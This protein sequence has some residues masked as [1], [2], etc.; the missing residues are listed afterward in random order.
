[1]PNLLR[2]PDPCTPFRRTMVLPVDQSKDVYVDA[3][4]GDVIK[5]IPLATNCNNNTGNTTWYGNKSFNAGYYGWPNNAWLLESHCP[6]EATMR[7]LRGDPLLIYNYGDADGS[8]TDAN[9]V[10]GYN[11]RAG[12]TTYWASIKLTIIIKIFIQD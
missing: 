1:M 9:G 10:N 11:Q 5:Q 2:Q 4:T 3:I 12:V 7:S 8:W 6:G